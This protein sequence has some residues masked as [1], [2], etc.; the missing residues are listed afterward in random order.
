MWSLK[1]A[2]LFCFSGEIFWD[3]ILNNDS[4]S[5]QVLSQLYRAYTILSKAVENFYQTFSQQM[6]FH[7]FKIPYQYEINELYFEAFLEDL[8]GWGVSGGWITHFQNKIMTSYFIISDLFP[9]VVFPFQTVTEPDLKNNRILD[10]LVKSLNFAR[11][12]LIL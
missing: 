4:C 10:E 3:G 6:L 12:D 8:V 1:R 5:C 7:C 9:S 11:Y 2:S